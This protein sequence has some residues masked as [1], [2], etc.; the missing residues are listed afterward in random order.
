[1][2]NGEILENRASHKM[3][4]HHKEKRKDDADRHDKKRRVNGNRQILLGADFCAPKE[5]SVGG[6]KRE[7]HG[8][9]H[10]YALRGKR[11]EEEGGP[12]VK[13]RRTIQESMPRS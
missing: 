1:M 10:A 13:L 9:G 7:E 11:G 6:E 3:Q 5:D 2:N 8:K 12:M 4:T